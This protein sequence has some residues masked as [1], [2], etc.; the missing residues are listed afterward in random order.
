M[1]ARLR[2]GPTIWSRLV[3][4]VGGAENIPRVAE[5]MSCSFRAVDT[6][7]ARAENAPP[8]PAVRRRRLSAA[9]ARAGGTGAGVHG[10]TDPAGARGVA[11]RKVP[12]VATPAMPS[13]MAW[14][15]RAYRPIRRSGSP[16]RN[17]I[18]H[19]GR[20]RSRRRRSCSAT[21][22]SAASSPGAGTTV[23]RTWSAR[24]NAGASVHSG[25]PSPGR[26]TCSTCRNRG[27][28]C[29]RAS[30]ACRAASIRNRPSGSSSRAPSRTASA[31]M[32]CGQRSS[33]HSMSR[34]SAVSRSID[35]ASWFPAS[36]RGRQGFRGGG[37][38]GAGPMTPA[39]DAAR[40][41]R[42]SWWAR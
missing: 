37:P 11:S 28:R 26:G 12:R 27:T 13:A 9:R 4:G 25:P 5:N 15:M 35:G 18:S 1:V 3:R 39:P 34:S 20:D 23:T 6:G 14:C 10:R 17:H 22:S 24:S 21:R 40:W 7:R 42:E 2:S 32:S 31:P 16:V 29:N 41:Q 33:G 8:T 38:F 30:T 19:S 36:T